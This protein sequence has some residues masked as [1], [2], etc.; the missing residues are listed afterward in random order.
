MI[1]S[2][3]PLVQAAINLP[4]SGCHIPPVEDDE[5]V[6]RIGAT[7]AKDKVNGL[8]AWV[9][10]K[11]K[12]RAVTTEASQKETAI[13]DNIHPKVN[14]EIPSTIPKTTT[15]LAR[16]PPPAA[17]SMS[18]AQTVTV[19]KEV[20]VRKGGDS[21]GQLEKLINPRGSTVSATQ[22]FT[23][24]PDQREPQN[25]PVTVKLVSRQPLP[26]THPTVHVSNRGEPTEAHRR[27]S[28]S[29]SRPSTTAELRNRA[30]CDTDFEGPGSSNLYATAKSDANAVTTTVS[31]K[32][33][34]LQDALPSSQSNARR[35]TLSAR[36]SQEH[37]PTHAL[38]TDNERHAPHLITSQLSSSHL[39]YPSSDPTF[40]RPQRIDLKRVASMSKRS[41]KDNVNRASNTAEDVGFLPPHRPKQSVLRKGTASDHQP[42]PHVPSMVSNRNP[43]HEQ[44]KVDESH[45][46]VDSQACIT[47][48]TDIHM[49]TG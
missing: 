22:M 38:P 31:S 4:C 6:R 40:L 30:K 8:N 23:P 12:R 29:N 32:E 27:T 16:E 25:M 46:R 44:T 11:C 19:R 36:S 37:H 3:E 35:R 39:S 34:N 9:C 18:Q 45:V 20:T 2:S 47:L 28:T 10:R 24:H 7:N 15:L 13:I 17:T 33:L 42:L 49:Y 48:M 1:F 41:Q 14:V 5:L 43:E 26:S 21:S